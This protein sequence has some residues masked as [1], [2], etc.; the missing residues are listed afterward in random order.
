[1][2]QNRIFNASRVKRLETTQAETVLG[3][4]LAIFSTKISLFLTRKID[5][6]DI[7]K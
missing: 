4:D 1:M 3:H 2:V 6:V 5:N 7:L